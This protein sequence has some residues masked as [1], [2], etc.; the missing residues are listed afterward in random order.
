MAY[1]HLGTEIIDNERKLA[2]IKRAGRNFLQRK[3]R[4]YHLKG[5]NIVLDEVYAKHP[6]GAYTRTGNLFQAFN[7]QLDFDASAD[8]LT[9]FMEPNSEVESYSG[10]GPAKWYPWYVAQGIFFRKKMA[11]RDFRKRWAQEIPFRQ[12]F[13]Q[14]IRSL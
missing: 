4:D 3:R 12:D 11:P 6:E 7:T 1:K 13:Y 2:G 14:Y 8:R 10:S 5:E 9:L